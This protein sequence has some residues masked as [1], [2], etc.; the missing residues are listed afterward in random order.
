MKL[1]AHEKAYLAAIINTK[2]YGSIPPPYPYLVYNYTLRRKYMQTALRFLKFSQIV[3]R[4][5]YGLLKI[6]WNKYR[7]INS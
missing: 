6:N 1:T 3:F 5:K 4:D 7:E 2:E